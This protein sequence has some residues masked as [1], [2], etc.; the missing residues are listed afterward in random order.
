[1]PDAPVFII[2]AA[3]FQKPKNLLFMR[4]FLWIVFSF[5]LLLA[6]SCSLNTESHHTPLIQVH[7]M[8]SG[9]DTLSV[10]G[11]ADGY[12]MDTIAVGDTV[13]F[14][15]SFYSYTN[16]L[17]GFSIVRE[18]EK[19]DIEYKLKADVDSLLTAASSDYEKGLFYVPAGYCYVGLQFNYIPKESGE[20]VN[21]LF[22]VDSDS[23]YPHNELNIKTPIR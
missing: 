11:T 12:V 19:A 2:F 21:L 3:R 13:L 7:S 5:S 18:E 6:T 23:N 8:V 14:T 17:T 22:T 10:L 20:N 4:K 16:L 1:M 15:V 9:T